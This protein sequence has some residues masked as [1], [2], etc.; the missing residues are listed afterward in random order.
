MC[1]SVQP[2][3]NPGHRSPP[4]SLHCS[5]AWVGIMVGRQ[6][7]DT[8]ARAMGCGPQTWGQNAVTEQVGMGAQG[9]PFGG[10]VVAS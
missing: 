7:T 5:Q 4:G 1:L 2:P 8:A 9:S 10:E 3:L 6:T